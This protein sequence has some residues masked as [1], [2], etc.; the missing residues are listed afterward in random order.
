M[1]L[2]II[3]VLLICL[4]LLIY[5]HHK[6]VCNELDEIKASI[7]SIS[8]NDLVGK[9]IIIP[10]PIH[11]EPVLELPTQQLINH[12]DQI[13]DKK[14]NETK[15]KQV[16]TNDIKQEFMNIINETTEEPKINDI[17][18]ESSTKEIPIDSDIPIINIPSL[19]ELE[20]QIL[21]QINQS[22]FNDN[23]MN[24]D[25][26]EV[27]N[28]DKH[29]STDSL[30]VEDKK[31]NEQSIINDDKD[32]IKQDDNINQEESKQDINDKQDNIIDQDDKLTD[33]QDNIINQDDK[34]TDIQENI[35][36]Q[37]N[38]PLIDTIQNILTS[39]YPYHV[40]VK[41]CKEIGL[42]VHNKKKV[43]IINILKSKI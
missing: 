26:I 33:K 20:Q 38:N 19:N 40:L 1:L 22:I 34:L 10:Q 5:F 31:D 41:K 37:Q 8:Q 39:D 29:E 43:D 18:Y 27:I 12:E 16:S 36:I 11:P 2:I 15:P 42:N 35:D 23:K 21:N 3:I 6:I 17:V 13:K 30:V 4:L 28:D 7:K 25:R 24:D 14:T 9:E 32:S